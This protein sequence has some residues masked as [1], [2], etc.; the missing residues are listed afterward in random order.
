MGNCRMNGTHPW[1]FSLVQALLPSYLC[2][3]K[4]CEYVLFAMRADQPKCNPVA[5]GWSHGREVVTEALSLSPCYYVQ[6]RVASLSHV[7]GMALKRRCEEMEDLSFG[8][9]CKRM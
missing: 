5:V 7:R 9:S 8:G 6:A 1:E 4:Y 2:T 3:S